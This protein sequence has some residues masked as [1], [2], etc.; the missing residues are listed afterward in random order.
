MIH[1]ERVSSSSE[2]S[3][4]LIG[5]N[6]ELLAMEELDD[7]DLG[8]NSD[9]CAMSVSSFRAASATAN[10]RWYHDVTPKLAVHFGYQP[11]VETI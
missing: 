5:R 3:E 9:A 8:C 4:I 1:F 7:C 6:E 10:N 11:C 2:V